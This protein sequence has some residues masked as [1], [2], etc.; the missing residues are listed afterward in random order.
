[1]AWRI[2][3]GDE[4]EKWFFGLAKLYVFIIESRGRDGQD[5]AWIRIAVE[6]VTTGSAVVTGMIQH[7]QQT[8]RWHQG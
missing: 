5:T 8:G 6:F 7:S 3:R 2:S 1:M 4:I